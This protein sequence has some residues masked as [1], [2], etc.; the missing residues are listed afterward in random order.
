MVRCV[1]LGQVVEAVG[2]V[3]GAP[4]S[5]KLAAV[6]TAVVVVAAVVVVVVV[7]VATAE[8]ADVADADTAGVAGAAGVAVG[9]DE[10]CGLARL[11]TALY[12][13]AESGRNVDELLDTSCLYQH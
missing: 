3:V 5:G 13:P 1:L 12:A 9:A 6:G 10:R 8:V 7:V 11:L 2:A 4:R